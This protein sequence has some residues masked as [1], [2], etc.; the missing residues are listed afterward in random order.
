[1]CN[2]PY[3]L[4]LIS[5]LCLVFSVVDPGVPPTPNF[6]KNIQCSQDFLDFLSTLVYLTAIDIL[7]FICAF[8]MRL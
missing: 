5:Y 1:M 6:K 7:V 2:T 3:V 8:Q 4:F